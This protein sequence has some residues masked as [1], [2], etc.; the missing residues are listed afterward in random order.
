MK[1]RRETG[2]CATSSIAGSCP[3][4]GV[5]SLSA[6]SRQPRGID[7]TAGIRRERVTRRAKMKPDRLHGHQKELSSLRQHGRRLDMSVVP[8]ED[9]VVVRRR[10]ITDVEVRTPETADSARTPHDALIDDDAGGVERLHEKTDVSS[11]LAGPV[12]DVPVESAGAPLFGLDGPLEHEVALP[13]GNQRCHGSG[14]DRVVGA[15]PACRQ[16]DGDQSHSY[17]GE[18]RLRHWFHRSLRWDNADDGFSYGERAHRA[19]LFLRKRLACLMSSAT[20]PA[21]ASS[22]WHHALALAC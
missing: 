19:G 20:V 22:Q 18:H 3:H 10:Q 9:L 13:A 15:E 6:G 12:E 21:G 11:I 2:S 8:H 14:W 7:E 4:R 1:G 16:N 17:Y 5:N